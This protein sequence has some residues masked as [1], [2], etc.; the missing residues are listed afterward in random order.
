M[1]QRTV[2]GTKITGVKL[3]K[4]LNQTVF[5]GPLR[6]LGELIEGLAVLKKATKDIDNE[7][8]AGYYIQL[9]E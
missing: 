6:V 9:Y 5:Q 7:Y 1:V 3:M 2:T 8:N 4:I